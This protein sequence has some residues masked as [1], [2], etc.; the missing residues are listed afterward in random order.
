MATST[1]L[2]L[3]EYFRARYEN[4]S[5]LIDGE[6]KPK[7]MGTGPHSRIQKRLVRHL[8]GKF[9]EA[10]LGEALP[11]MSLR[12]PNGDVLIPD[13]MFSRREQAFNAEGIFDTPPLLCVE[14]VSPSQSFGELVEK[15]SKYSRFGVAFCWIID[16]VR[17]V[18]WQIEGELPARRIADDG[19]LTAG[20][21]TVRVSELFG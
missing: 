21:I 4:E 20:Q 1:R 7:P 13:V 12:L 18:A 10:G 16:P 9:E 8:L 3:Q 14:I 19:I 15:S 6:L 5:E 11:E 2:S 17:E